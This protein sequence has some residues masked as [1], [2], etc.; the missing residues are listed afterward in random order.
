VGPPFIAH[1]YRARWEEGR[2]I[3]D[4]DTITAI[5]AEVG[6]PA[7]ELHD[8]VDDPGVRAEGL[9]A[10]LSIHADGVFG[11]PFFTHGRDR[12]WGIDRLAE[13]ATALRSD[14]TDTGAGLVA[15]TVSGPAEARTE[16]GP[17]ADQGHAG[18]CG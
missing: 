16:H 4:R 3:S 10:L 5:G 2:N 12:Y 15:S 18:G 1:V 11:V 13:F 14:A 7:G 9:A 6:V 17:A 8:T